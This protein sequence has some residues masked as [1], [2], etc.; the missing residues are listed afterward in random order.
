MQKN[1]LLVDDNEDFA[2]YFI[3]KFSYLGKLVH[4]K[5]HSDAIQLIKESPWDLVFLDHTLDSDKTC[6]D[7]IPL[8]R[9]SH[10]RSHVLIVTG[11]ADKAMAIRAANSGV[12]GFLEKPILEDELTRR[13]QEIGWFDSRFHLDDKSRELIV[14]DKVYHLTQ[15]EYVVLRRLLDRKNQL[16]TRADLEQDIWNGRHV[17]KNALDTHLYN[18]KKKI[19]ELKN[20]LSSVHGTG[21]LLKV[22]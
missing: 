11:N 20:C 9:T 17:A 5:S 2:A 7:L 10:P 21:Y 8:V 12:S 4:T 15:V 14:G 22:Q 6:F 18:L 3:S 19:P 13:L 1:I 16:V